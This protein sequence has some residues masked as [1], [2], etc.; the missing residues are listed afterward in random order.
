[1]D[2]RIERARE[3]YERAIFAGDTSGL[4]AAELLDELGVFANDAGAALHVGLAR[5]NPLRRLLVGSKG[6]LGVT[7]A[8]HGGLLGDGCGRDDSHR[9]CAGLANTR[10]GALL[11]GALRW[12]ARH[13]GEPL[14]VHCGQ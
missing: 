7:V 8:R 1:M 12:Q 14:N 9:R 2:E 3:Q 6:R 10:A 4:A 11:A 13:R 5:G